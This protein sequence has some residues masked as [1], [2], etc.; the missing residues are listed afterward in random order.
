[1]LGVDEA[2]ATLLE[3]AHPIGDGERVPLGNAAGRIALQDLLSPI[4]VPGFD[5]S[6]MDG[7]ALHS[8]DMALAQTRGLDVSQRIPAGVQ[9]KPLH[10]GSAARIFTGAPVPEG[11]DTVVMQEHCRIEN[12]RLFIGKPPEAGANIRPRG[13]D[14]AAGDT[15]LPAGTLLQAAQLGLA[16]SVGIAEIE[17]RRRLRV[18]IFSTGDELVE[19]G[20]SL[21][22]GQ[23]Y[24]SN[25]Y[26]LNA[27]LYAQ[28]CDVVDLGS[29]ADSLEATRRTLSTAAEQADLVIASGGVSVG[30]EDHVKAA[31]QSLGELTLWRVRMKPGK[32]LAYGHI[33]AVPFLGLPGNP[34]SVYVTFLLFARPYLQRLQGRIRTM[35]QTW[36][37]AAGFDHRT[38]DRREYLRVRVSGDPLRG[39][40]AEKY[41][42]QGS[43][44]L[45][46]VAW[47]DGLVEIAENAQ[48]LPG[49]TLRYLAFAEWAR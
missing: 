22:P 34:V 35:P 14:I 37:V 8:R 40:T 48:V 5:N 25:R 32:P 11:A 28:G 12:D 7:Y 26:L 41:P 16:A 2:V 24:N 15:I 23:I 19:P 9:G 30:E 17:V 10:P 27:L 18:A 21:A 4:D 20:Q 44:V 1:M 38:S 13:N 46:S 33:G 39:L 36:P 31:L 42:R 29:I 49:D 6:A 47:A 45:S 43:D 3:H